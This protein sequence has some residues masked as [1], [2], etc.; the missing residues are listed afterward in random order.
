M[1]LIENSGSK[2]ESGDTTEVV[3][4][5]RKA[6]E[7]M[8]GEKDLRLAVRLGKNDVGRQMVLVLDK[9]EEEATPKARMQKVPAIKNGIWK[10]RIMPVFFGKGTLNQS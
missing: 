3:D 2:G 7:A 4:E 1:I 5:S 8:F 10:T 9:P 6:I